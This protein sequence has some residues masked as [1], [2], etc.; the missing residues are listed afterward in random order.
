MLTKEGTFALHNFIV[1]FQISGQRQRRD[2]MREQFYLWQD[3]TVP[4][5]I[6]SLLGML[7]F[8]LLHYSQIFTQESLF[9]TN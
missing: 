9:S 1:L 2:T 5:E 6:D 8:A 7:K 3:R 4:Y